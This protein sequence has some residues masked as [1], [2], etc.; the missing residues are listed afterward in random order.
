[1]H[2]LHLVQRLYKHGIH[3]NANLGCLNIRVT[4][5]STTINDVFFFVS[6]LRKVYYNNY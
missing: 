1:M 5:N 2:I 3:M 4:K 6:D